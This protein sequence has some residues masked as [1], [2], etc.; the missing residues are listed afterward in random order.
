MNDFLTYCAQAKLLRLMENDG[1]AS[2]RIIVLH[3]GSVSIEMLHEKPTWTDI[4]IS[5]TP[6]VFTD[7]FTLIQLNPA[8]ID[9]DYPS[10]EFVITREKHDVPVNAR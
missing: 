8:A 10:A 1:A 9:F 7:L 3:E 2:V 4:M 6:M 5:A